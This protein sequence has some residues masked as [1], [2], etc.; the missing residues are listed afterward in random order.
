MFKTKA[1][2]LFTQKIR[3]TLFRVVI[4]SEEYGKISAWFQ[5]WTL[6]FD[7]GDIVSVSIERNQG[8]NT[9]KRIESITSPRWISWTYDTLSSFLFL[10]KLYY[11]FL[12]ESLPHKKIYD[13]YASFLSWNTKKW[14]ST[15]WACTL[16]QLR[17]LKELWLVGENTFW[18]NTLL[19][20][21]ALWIE[22]KD[23]FTILESKKI[24]DSHVQEMFLKNLSILHQYT[25]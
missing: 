19:N 15:S 7:I 6:S 11:F 14:S 21:I 24:S 23:L 20:Y 5:K 18:E 13:D 25:H 17:F 4:F 2:I 9:I 3:D 1:I 10:V 16:M 8:K 12:P 22:K